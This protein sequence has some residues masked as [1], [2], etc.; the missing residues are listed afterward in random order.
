MPA[1]VRRSRPSLGGRLTRSRSR[2]AGGAAGGIAAFVTTPMD[3]I[4]TQINCNS[5]LRSLGVRAVARHM[6]ASGGPAAFFA[7]VIPRLMERVPA[8]AVYWLAAEATRRVLEAGA[9]PRGGKGASSRQNGSSCEG[10]GEQEEKKR[11]NR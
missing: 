6:L 5:S 10:G 1:A 4:K 8:S 7:G 11:T 2:A 3:C 9:A